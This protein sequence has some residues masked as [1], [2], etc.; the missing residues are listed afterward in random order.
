MERK[1]K[2]VKRIY[3]VVKLSLKSPLALSGGVS[4]S[5]DMDVLRNGKGE[6]FIPGTSLAGAFRSY[7]QTENE[8]K[9]EGLFGYA[10]G[11]R[12]AMS[13]VHIADL[14]FDADTKPIVSVRDG[15]QLGAN[16]TVENKFDMEIIET[17]AEGKLYVE[18]ILRENDWNDIKKENPEKEFAAILHGINTGEIR[19]GGNKNRGFGRLRAKKIWQAVFESGHVKEWITFCENGHD[20]STLSEGETCESWLKDHLDREDEAP[21]TPEYIHYT[22]PLRL[23]GGIS[24]RRYSTKPGEADFEHI[25]CHMSPAKKNSA[26]PDFED[27]DSVK[28]IIPGTSWNG[29]IR[30]DIRD[31]LGRLGCTDG[32]ICELIDIWFGYVDVKKNAKEQRA[33]QSMIVFGESVLEGG[34]DVPMTRNKINRFDSSTI[35]SA[36]YSEITHCGGETTLD[37]MIQTGKRGTKGENRKY[38]LALLAMLRLVVQDLGRGYLAVGGQTAIGRGVFTVSGEPVLLADGGEEIWKEAQQQLMTVIKEKK[39]LEEKEE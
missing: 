32:K 21:D 2:I 13:S 6:L 33:K 25:T 15:V 34:E 27:W 30:A 26:K 1:N 29:A 20:A 14:Y 36:L 3:Y 8:K 7:L 10:D 11:E 28:P 37:I 19:L 39:V 4:E 18:Y 31:I 9:T 35:E 16:K 38:A 17:G 12:G 24:I 22:I 5:T 23:T